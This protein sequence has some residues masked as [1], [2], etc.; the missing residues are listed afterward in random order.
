MANCHQLTLFAEQSGEGNRLLGLQQAGGPGVTAVWQ[1][2]HPEPRTQDTGDGE[3][4]YQTDCNTEQAKRGTSYLFITLKIL[5]FPLSVWAKISKWRANCWKT[6]V[7]CGAGCPVEKGCG[8]KSQLGVSLVCI[9][10]PERDWFLSGSK[11]VTAVGLVARGYESFKW[12]NEL[13]S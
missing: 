13:S 7:V 1:R 5:I 3:D 12:L 8:F 11:H 6:R 9:L 10:L 2:T 4:E